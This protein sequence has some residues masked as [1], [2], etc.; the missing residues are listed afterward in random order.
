MPGWPRL[1]AASKAHALL[2]SAFRFYAAAAEHARDEAWPDEVWRH[3]RHRRATLARLLARDGMMSQV[4]DEY[5][6]VRE[7]K[8]KLQR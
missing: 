1:C 4:A 7:T 2:L 3:W 5:S 6:S 8:T